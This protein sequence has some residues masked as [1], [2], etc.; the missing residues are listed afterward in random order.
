MDLLGN[1]SALLCVEV[2]NVMFMNIVTTVRRL[3]TQVY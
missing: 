1:Q 2:N 3:L